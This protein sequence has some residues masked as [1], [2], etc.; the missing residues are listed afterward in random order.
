[1]RKCKEFAASSGWKILEVHIYCDKAVSGKSRVMRE[2]LLRLFVG[3]LK[4]RS[5]VRVDCEGINE[6]EFRLK[7]EK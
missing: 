3:I 7:R 1:M 6:Y 5:H 4:G 2:S